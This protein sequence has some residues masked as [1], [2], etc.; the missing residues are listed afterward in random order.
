MLKLPGPRKV[1]T[2]AL[3]SIL[4]VLSSLLIPCRIH[5]HIPVGYTI[6]FGFPFAFVWQENV[7]SPPYADYWY[8]LD[9]PHSSPTR[10]SGEVFLLNV[11]IVFS[12]LY[13]AT[14]AL[15]HLKRRH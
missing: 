8:Y 15:R 12:L 11:A 5:G 9:L 1:I 3:V 14:V 4:L 2:L 10:T 6:S 13:A 7:Y